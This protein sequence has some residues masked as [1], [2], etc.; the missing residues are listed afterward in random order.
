ME[1]SYMKITLKSGKEVKV[2]NTDVLYLEDGSLNHNYMKGRWVYNSAADNFGIVS[3]TYAGSEKEDKAQSPKFRG[4]TLGG[5]QFT[6]KVSKT[7][8]IP[9]GMMPDLSG[10]KK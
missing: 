2:L 8:V 1:V 4:T 9:A 5:N 3:G 10:M 7:D 6:W